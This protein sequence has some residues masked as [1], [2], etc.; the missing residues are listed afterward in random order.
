VSDLV[1]L[2]VEHRGNLVVARLRGEL[3]ISEAADVG[4]RIASSLEPSARGAVVDLTGLSFMDS[5]GV[6]MLFA[7][8]RRLASHRQEL[9]IVAPSQG[10]V[11]RVLDIVGFG[12]AATVHEGLDAALESVD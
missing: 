8:S 6:A 2:E 5:S 10:P 11:G 4:E 12:R 9:R 1:G 7:L 3:D